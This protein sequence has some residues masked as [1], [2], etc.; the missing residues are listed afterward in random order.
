MVMIDPGQFLN[1]GIISSPDIWQ[2][3]DMNFD[4]LT[5][6][7]L[8]NLE[9]RW[10]LPPITSSP[11]TEGPP[12][13]ITLSPE[14]QDLVNRA[15]EASRSLG[16]ENLKTGAIQSAG[17][18]GLNLTDTPI[19]EPYM[20]SLALLESQTA[21]GRANTM[22]D[23]LQR[24][25]ELGEQSRRFNVGQEFQRFGLN[26]QIR[27]FQEELRQ[28]AFQNRLN[29]GQQFGAIGLGLAGAR[30]GRNTGSTQT[31][32]LNTALGFNTL[33]SGGAQLGRSINVLTG[34]PIIPGFGSGTTSFLGF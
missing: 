34:Q 4:A 26:E 15:F 2:N 27:Q 1:G 32:P 3:Q 33:A 16:A 23:L 30:L 29:L 31:S 10:G 19:S 22:L 25:R 9:Q 28:R 8:D 14:V 6:A 7:E 24:N 17:Q 20:R 18:R 11:E 13:N 12:S 5:D 21:S